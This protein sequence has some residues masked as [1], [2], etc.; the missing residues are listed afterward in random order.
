MVVSFLYVGRN[1]SLKEEVI[2]SVW[3]EDFG[4]PLLFLVKY[5]GVFQTSDT[6]VSFFQNY[7]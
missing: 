5:D 7:K 3:L 2:N 4:Q 6:Y 1:Y